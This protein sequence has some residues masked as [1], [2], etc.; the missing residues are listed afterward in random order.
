MAATT[1]PFA[2]AHVANDPTSEEL[3]THTV[4]LVLR[5][6]D[7][8]GTN[9]YVDGTDLFVWVDD[10]TGEAH[11]VLEDLWTEGPPIFHGGTIPDALRWIHELGEPFHLQLEDPFIAC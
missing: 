1:V 9:D 8:D 5:T 4:R 3:P 6:T 2:H 11:F 10:H 7:E